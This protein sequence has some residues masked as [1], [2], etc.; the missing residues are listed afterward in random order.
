MADFNSVI[1]R[2]LRNEGGTLS[3][4]NNGALVRWGRNEAY[5][6]NMPAGFYTRGVSD[7]DAKIAATASYRENEWTQIMG[8]RIPN[9][10]LAYE[11][12][13][14][15]VN[16]GVETA[17]LILQHVIAL[18]GPIVCDGIMGPVT[19][20]WIGSASNILP[21]QYCAARVGFY[22]GRRNP[23]WLKTWLSRI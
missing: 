21:L 16:A 13:D 7:A 17:V 1:E 8:D 18:S 11:M 6:P 4:D 20:S 9:Q 5:W 3:A 22:I 2:V 14:M 12:M 15:A 10:S 23:A 19:L